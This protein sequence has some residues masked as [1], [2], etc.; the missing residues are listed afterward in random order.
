MTFRLT[1]EEIVRLVWRLQPAADAW[2]R[3]GALRGELAIRPWRLT[4]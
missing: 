1:D 3:Y 2:S 4:P